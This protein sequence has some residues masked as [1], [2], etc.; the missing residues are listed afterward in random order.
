MGA[1]QGLG[2][3]MTPTGTKTFVFKYRFAGMTLVTYDAMSL[4]DAHEAHAEALKLLRLG[5][6]PGAK[7]LADRKEERRAPTVAELA[8]E[9]LEKWAKPRRRSW[10][11]DKRI[12][13]KDVL[14]VGT[15]SHLA[16]GGDCEASRR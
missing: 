3:R 11:V 4:A 10:A 12:S 15:L 9:Y 1:F 5:F 6:D 16:F 2:V 8:A 7:A 13:E 14:P